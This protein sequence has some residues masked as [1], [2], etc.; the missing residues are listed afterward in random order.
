[1]VGGGIDGLVYAGVLA[2]EGNKGIQLE[3]NQLVRV[4]MLGTND[5]VMGRAAR[6]CLQ[7]ERNYDTGHAL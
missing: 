7:T 6:E 5:V 4:P 2:K 1:M 3:Q